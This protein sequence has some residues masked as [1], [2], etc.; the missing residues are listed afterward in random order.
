MS[1]QVTIDGF[2]RIQGIVD[3]VRFDNAIDKALVRSGQILRDETK[4]M[5]PVSA[6]RT[7]YGAKGIPVA[8]KY[9]G[10]LRDEIYSKRMSRLAV[11]IIAPVGYSLYVHQGTSKMPGRP[12]FRWALEV[13][14]VSKL[15]ENEFT[16]QI[17]NSLNG[18]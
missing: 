14:G 3:P 2:D 7:G 10:T 1:F 12:F 15:I 9:G 17:S 5:P 13:F 11:G 16:R 8:P 6:S 4:K 18:R